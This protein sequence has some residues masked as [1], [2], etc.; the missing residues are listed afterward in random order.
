MTILHILRVTVCVFAQKTVP[1]FILE[2]VQTRVWVNNITTVTVIMVIE[3]VG[4]IPLLEM[5]STLQID[6]ECLT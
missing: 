5:E 3:R 1:Y 2:Y 6:L 4:T